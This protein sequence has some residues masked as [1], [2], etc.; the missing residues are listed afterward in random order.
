VLTSR[1]SHNIYLTAEIF[2]ALE[3][4]KH[5]AAYVIEMFWVLPSRTESVQDTQREFLVFLPLISPLVNIYGWREDVRRDGTSCVMRKFI[6][7]HLKSIHSI[8]QNTSF[9]V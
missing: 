5:T 9:L 3:R 8:K 4:V 2:F 1:H 7:V 6:A